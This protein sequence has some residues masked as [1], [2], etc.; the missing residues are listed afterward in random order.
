[1]HWCHSSS[2]PAASTTSSAVLCL[3]L[4]AVV[5]SC[6]LCF[7]A[8]TSV[9]KLFFLEILVKIVCNITPSTLFVLQTLGFVFVS[10]PGRKGPKSY[11]LETFWDI[12]FNRSIITMTTQHFKSISSTNWR[13]GSLVLQFLVSEA[14]FLLRPSTFS[15]RSIS[16]WWNIFLS[17]TLQFLCAL[18]IT[19]IHNLHSGNSWCFL[20]FHF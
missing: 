14:T 8:T 4:K 18:Q 5:Y 12:D 3:W 11:F 10:S 13:L 19:C 7:S 20:W 6:S 15:L 16:R 1:M 17:P 2:S 9:G